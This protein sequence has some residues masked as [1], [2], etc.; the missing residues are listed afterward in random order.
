MTRGPTRRALLVCTSAGAALSSARS[1]AA[2]IAEHVAV[3]P[4]PIANVRLLPSPFLDALAANRA[5]LFRLDAD[6]LL[7]NYRAQAGLAPKGASYGGWEAETI[8]GHTL[9]HYLSALSLL[10]AQTGDPEARSR[11]AYIVDELVLCQSRSADGY[12]AGFT[13][14]RDGVTEPGRAA[15]DEIRRGDIR[16]SGFDLNGAWSP[17]Y[18]WHK[19]LAGLLDAERHCGNPRALGV[20]TRLSNYLA[21]IFAHLDDDQV[22]AVL[23]CE[24]GGLN[25]SLAELYARTGDPADLRLA[26]RIHDRR[27]LDPLARGQDDLGGLHANTQIPKIVGLARLFEITGRTDHAIASTTFWTAATRHHAYVIGGVG[28]REYFT[29]PDSSA[30][31]VTEQTCETCASYNMLKLARHLYARDPDAALFDAYERIQINHI[32]AQHDPKTGMFTYMMPLMSGAVREWSTPFDDFWCCVGTGM[33]SH[34]K[35]GDSV[36]WTSGRDTVIVNLFV[37]ATMHWEGVGLALETAYPAD[38]Q[39]GIVVTASRRRHAWTLRL[40]VPGWSRDTG[41]AV[42]GEPVPVARDADGYASLRRAWR[43]GDRVTLRLDMRIRT[44][45][46][47]GSGRLV[48]FLRGP[49]VLAADLG[50]ASSPFDGVTPA[51]VG[52]VDELVDRVTPMPDAPGRFRLGGIARPDDLV[53]ASFADARDRRSAVYFPVFIAQEWHT[54]EARFRA[55]EADRRALAARAADAFHPGEMQSERDHDL[56]ATSSYP[57]T[58]RFRHGRDARDGGFFAFRMCGRP[59]PLTLRLTYWGEERNRLFRILV[60]GAAIATVALDGTHPGTFFDA[61]YGIPEHLTAGRATLTIRIEPL[62]GHSAG[63]VFDALLLAD[64]TKDPRPP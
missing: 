54:E 18:N 9:G 41:L 61:A 2:S 58:Y 22:Q 37:P 38:G 51:L 15:F 35:H 50:P 30:E 53:L 13:R 11:V 40:R 62:R 1:R 14:I 3:R 26:E 57:L 48:S 32:L 21:G 23:A 59:G 46:P 25:E 60:D 31:Y 42:N 8:A 12:V 39:V 5:Y 45:T 19:L 49:S 7:H 28:D 63:P 24:Y 33:E 10:H 17:L 44:E 4:V 36:F 55:D 27:T 52:D 6:R 47:A 56:V 43:Q 16:S 64:E 34:A 29:A 20:A